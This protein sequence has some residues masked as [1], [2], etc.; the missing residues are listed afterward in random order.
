MHTR[1]SFRSVVGFVVLVVLAAACTSETASPTTTASASSS[2]TQAATPTPSPMMDDGTYNL[3]GELTVKGVDPSP[4]GSV[5]KAGGSLTGK[6][7]LGTT[8]QATWTITFHGMTGPVE[9]AMISHPRG[10]GFSPML[11]CAPCESGQPLVT[12]FPS[13]AVAEQ[14]L[15]QALDGKAIVVLTTKQNPGGEIGGKVEATRV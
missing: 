7:T 1:V 12:T 8:W 11:L 6:A 15:S 5:A 3:V 2:P 9:S 10:D 4:T 13:R 14:F